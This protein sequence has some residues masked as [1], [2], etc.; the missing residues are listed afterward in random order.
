MDRRN[1]NKKTI[2]ELIVAG[3]TP[4]SNDDDTLE[5][6]RGFYENLY[7]TDLGE[8]STSLFQGFTENLR[9]K[10]P[11]LS[12]DQKDLLEGKLTLE[13]CKRALWCL[14]LGK[15]SDEDGFTLEFYQIFFELLGQEFLDSINASYDKNELSI[16]QRR[17]MI[18]IIPK[19]D[20]NLKDPSCFLMLI[21][22]SHPKPLVLE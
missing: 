2:T 21:T 14:R 12:R 15:L 1:Y 9:N 20:P 10:L 5:E 19:E 8:D 4:I 16:S 18:T 7:E 22:K 11:K 13:E 3:G 17:G 6:I